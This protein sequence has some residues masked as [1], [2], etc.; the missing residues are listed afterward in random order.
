M[1]TNNLLARQNPDGGWPYA[2]GK[3]WTEP[4]VYAVMALLA[5]GERAAA[6]RGL[7]WIKRMRRP[8]GGWAP[9]AGVDQSTWVTAAVALLPPEELG[10]ALYEGAIRWLLDVKGEE[11]TFLYRLRGWLI[12]D[13]ARAG[14]GDPG[15]PWI[16][17]AA[18]WV[19]PTALAIMALEKA[20]R[21]NPSGQ[22]RRRIDQGRGFLLE[23]TCKVGGWNHGFPRGLGL[24]SPPYAETTGMGLAAFRGV[25]GPKVDRAIGVARNFLAGCRSAG[26]LNWLQLGLMA[27]G[28]LP[29]EYRA[30]SGLTCRTVLEA[31]LYSLI[32]VSGREQH[33]FWG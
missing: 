3:S 17:G 21:R 28:E 19:G 16:P 14:D 15:W 24:E 33:F 1:P 30:P 6:G 18:A 7:A 11:F 31:S 5:A 25:K 4:T 8:D 23:R 27:H 26:A 29:S 2:N 13:V 22:I 20:G 10:A 32:A 9:Q 12:G